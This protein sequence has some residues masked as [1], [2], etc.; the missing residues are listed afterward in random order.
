MWLRSLRPTTVTATLTDGRDT[1]ECYVDRRHEAPA[2]R[3]AR[4]R[5]CL[6]WLFVQLLRGH[7]SR[8]R[9]V[10]RDAILC[11]PEQDLHDRETRVSGVFKN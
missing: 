9:G 10:G 4:M 8:I 2:G 7:D 1:S 3:P 6:S 11:F 5:G